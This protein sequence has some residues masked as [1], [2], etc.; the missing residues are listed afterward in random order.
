MP[1]FPRQPKYRWRYATALV[2][3]LSL[4]AVMAMAQTVNNPS[5]LIYP[6]QAACLARSQSQC[7]ALGCDGVK[8]VYW[9]NVI[10]PLNAGTI[11]SVA[12]RAVLLAVFV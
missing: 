5:C 6:S 3:A 12:M 8:T 2:A 4:S 10:G 11:N 7:A 9:W 1:T